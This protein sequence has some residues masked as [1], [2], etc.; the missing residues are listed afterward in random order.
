MEL[1][2]MKA[3][4]G[5][6]SANIEKQQRITDTIIVQITKMN[7]RNT[8]S[9]ILLPEAAGSLICIATVVFICINFQL[10][11]TWYLQACGIVSVLLMIAMPYFSLKAICAVRR[12]NVQGNT[13]KQTLQAYS[14]G[15]LFFIKVQKANFYMGA[16]LMLAILP[17]MGALI[18]GKNLFTQTWLWYIYILAYPFFNA[19]SKWVFKHYA[20]TIAEAENVLKALEA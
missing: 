17:V 3:I 1:E 10:L 7:Y 20:K 12:V 2:E 16:V 8:L 18:S 4:W 14:A 9:R 5:E 13:Y 15:K 6:M 19:F 11:N